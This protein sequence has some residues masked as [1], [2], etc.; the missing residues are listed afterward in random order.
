MDTKIK[1]ID[2]KELISFIDKEKNEKENIDISCFCI[3]SQQVVNW[4]CEKGHQFKEKIYVMYRKKIS[5]LFVLEG[6]YYQAITIY[7][8]YIL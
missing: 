2:M 4:I 6:R 7:K 8:H 3:H 1:V 5:V